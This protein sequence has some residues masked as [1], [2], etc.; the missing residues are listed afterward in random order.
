MKLSMTPHLGVPCNEINSPHHCPQHMPLLPMHVWM[1]ILQGC[2]LTFFPYE[3]IGQDSL[4]WRTFLVSSIW[5]DRF[6]YQKLGLKG[7]S[8]SLWTLLTMSGI[9]EAQINLGTLWDVRKRKRLTPEA[10][11][12]W[13]KMVPLKELHFVR[14]STCLLWYHLSASP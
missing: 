2:V 11:R 7:G 14:I 1:E 10:A 9:P 4:P 13:G 12:Q 6:M 5:R 3:T 8:V